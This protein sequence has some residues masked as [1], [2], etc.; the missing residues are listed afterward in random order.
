MLKLFFQKQFG[1]LNGSCISVEVRLQYFILN[2]FQMFGEIE[3]AVREE[4]AVRR[5][6]VL[7]VE[8]FELFVGQVRYVTRL[9]ARVEFVLR[10]LEE[11]LG[12]AVEESRA[13]IAHGTF[14]LV[15]DDTF[16]FQARVDVFHIG[17]FQ[18]VTFL[19]EVQIA[20][21]REESGI[22]VNRHEIPVILSVLAGKWIHSE[23]G[24]SPCIH[25]GVET[26]LDHVHEWI[27]YRIHA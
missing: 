19:T 8:C 9:A 21:V 16:V 5:M 23:V 25:V 1:F 10:L 2:E 4:R 3:I 22:S 17:E 24:S 15:V 27:S 13:R 12:H 11:I 6:I 14:H 26:S 20:Q 18:S 7:L